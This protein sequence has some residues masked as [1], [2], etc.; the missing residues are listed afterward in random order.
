MNKYYL[1]KVIDKNGVHVKNYV[2]DLE[3]MKLGDIIHEKF[4]KF[5]KE[6]HGEG[7]TFV[8]NEV[9]GEMPQDIDRIV[10]DLPETKLEYNK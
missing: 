5:L 9:E 4:A 6:E 10:I 2:T 1:L 3:I 7:T 8:F